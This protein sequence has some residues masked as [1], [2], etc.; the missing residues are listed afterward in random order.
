MFV[1]HAF[2]NFLL[3]KRQNKEIHFKTISERA[4]QFFKDERY[5]NT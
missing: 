3:N 2:C 5:A 4:F 1:H